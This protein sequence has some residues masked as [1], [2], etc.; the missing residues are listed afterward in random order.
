MTKL[1]DG[2][3]VGLELFKFDT[4]PYCRRV[5]DYLEERSVK[6]IRLRDIRTEEGAADELV[7]RGGKQQVPALFVDGVPLYESADILAW[8]DTQVASPAIPKTWEKGVS[9]HVESQRK[10]AS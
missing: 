3:E 8:L 5:L 9:R 10:A 4:C 2:R 7:V 1:K 6:E